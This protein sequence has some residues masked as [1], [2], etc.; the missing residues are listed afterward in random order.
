MTPKKNRGS[1]F[2]RQRRALIN[3]QKETVSHRKERKW[4]LT[5]V[6]KN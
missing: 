5:I 6:Q 4:T 2:F 3:I 1:I